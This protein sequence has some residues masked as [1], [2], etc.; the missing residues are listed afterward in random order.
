VAGDEVHP[1]TGRSYC[2]MWESFDRDSQPLRPLELD[3]D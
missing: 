3:L 2:S 1:Q